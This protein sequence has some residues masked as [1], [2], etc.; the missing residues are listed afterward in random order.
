MIY[1]LFGAIAGGILLGYLCFDVSDKPALDTT[2]MTALNFMIL[3]AG[4]KVVSS[5]GLSLTSKHRYP[6]R[7]PPAIAPNKE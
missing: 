3:V 4:I 1:S 6:K 2:L 5:A 7:I